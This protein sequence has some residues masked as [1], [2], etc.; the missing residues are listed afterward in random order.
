MFGPT[1]AAK[2]VGAAPRWSGWFSLAARVAGAARGSR[3]RAVQAHRI[4]ISLLVP[5]KPVPTAGQY[6][7]HLFVRG[8]WESVVISPNGIEL[9]VNNHYLNVVC[10]SAE[11][12]NRLRRGD[13]GGDGD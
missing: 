9:C 8:L 3:L 12:L 2:P 10:H 5:R 11:T 6:L 7:Q 4:L 1:W 13:R